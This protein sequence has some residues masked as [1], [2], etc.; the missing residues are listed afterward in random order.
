MSCPTF[1][2]GLALVH[3]QEYW[4]LMQLAKKIPETFNLNSLCSSRK[5]N[6]GGKRASFLS[7]LFGSSKVKS[8]GNPEQKS[9]LK[10]L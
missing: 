8:Q 10:I 4:L 3:F 5:E 7:C 1:Y 2:M 9:N 6:E